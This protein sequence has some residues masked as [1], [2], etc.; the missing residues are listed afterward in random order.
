VILYRRGGTQLHEGK[1]VWLNGRAL[2]FE[3]KGWGFEPLHEYDFYPFDSWKEEDHSLFTFFYSLI[4]KSWLLA[5]KLT[6]K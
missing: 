1:L 2:V 4:G 3:T 5:A 6:T